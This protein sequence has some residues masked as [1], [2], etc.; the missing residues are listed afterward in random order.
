MIMKIVYAEEDRGMDIIQIQKYFD[1]NNYIITDEDENPY[2]EV[3]IN[4][5]GK[6]EITTHTQ[7]ED[8]SFNSTEE[9]FTTVEIFTDNMILIK[10]MG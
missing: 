7:L 9:L 5:K 6:K 4:D 10:K 1:D 3:L 2:Y 8:D